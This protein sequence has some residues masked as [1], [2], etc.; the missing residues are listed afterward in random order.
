M[1]LFAIEGLDSL[2]RKNID[3]TGLPH[4]W[5]YSVWNIV[6]QEH[7]FQY[8]LR[9]SNEK[10][11]VSRLRN[12]VKMHFLSVFLSVER[13]CKSTKFFWI[14]KFFFSQAQKRMVEGCGRKTERR[15]W[16]YWLWWR[17]TQCRKGGSP[18]VGIKECTLTQHNGDL[19]PPLHQYL[20]DTIS[21][22]LFSAQICPQKIII[23]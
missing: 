22:H 1:S 15:G 10:C 19:Y 20:R 6:Q 18:L 17:I 4:R 16:T 2:L 23:L 5:I 12:N 9:N 21:T 14:C 13:R 11:P 7:H 3:F 8:S